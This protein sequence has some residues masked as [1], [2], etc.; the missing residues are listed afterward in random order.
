MPDRMKINDRI[1]VA[2]Q[3][4]ASELAS[5]AEEGFRSV[6]NLRVTNEQEDMLSPVDEG[7][8]VRGH[9]MTYLHLPVSMKQI[10]PEQVDEFGNAVEAL[11]APIFVHCQSGKRSGAFVMMREA[12]AHGWSGEET[13]EKA[14][15]MGFECEQAELREFVKQYVDQHQQA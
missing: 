13:L 3:P 14:E 1:T 12:I 10:R 5:L 15:A 9:G 7:N 8:E 11:E 2:G 6:I 4:D